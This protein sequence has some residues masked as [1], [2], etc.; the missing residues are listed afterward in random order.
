M[1]LWQAKTV[2]DIL[3][4]IYDILEGSVSSSQSIE[5]HP[6]I[7]FKSTEDCVWISI[8]YTEISPLGISVY[9]Q[10]TSPKQ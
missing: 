6:L 1:S 4:A 8:F 10:G 3:M 5:Q 9:T 7:Y 2:K